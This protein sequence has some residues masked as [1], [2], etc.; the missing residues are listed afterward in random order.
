MIFILLFLYIY[1][2]III[3]GGGGA[4]GGGI[5]GRYMDRHIYDLLCCD[6]AKWESG[7]PV[8]GKKSLKRTSSS[9]L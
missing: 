2:I 1:I 4:E 9:K 7:Q 8:I 5:M 3:W 6:H